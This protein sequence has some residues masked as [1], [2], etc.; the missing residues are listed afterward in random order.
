MRLIDFVG[1]G[2]LWN[3]GAV[4]QAPFSTVLRHGMVTLRGNSEC[5]SIYGEALTNSMICA[6]DESGIPDTCFGDSG[7]PLMCQSDGQW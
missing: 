1:W 3:D 7:G 2:K 4:K 5:K 6:G